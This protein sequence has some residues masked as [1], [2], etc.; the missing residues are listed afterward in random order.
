[1]NANATE[2]AL[3]LS[4]L[5][6]QFRLKAT[7]L[8][9]RHILQRTDSPSTGDLANLVKD[10]KSAAD[11]AGSIAVSSDGENGGVLVQPPSSKE[12]SNE[13]S[14]EGESHSDN[15]RADQHAT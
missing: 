1:V 4:D 13:A 11:G 9:E 2:L 12:P 5:E 8:E 6:C 7:Q 15:S 14:V 3:R 10:A